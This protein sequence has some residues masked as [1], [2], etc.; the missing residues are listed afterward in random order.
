M[1]DDFLRDLDAAVEQRCACLCGQQITAMSPSAYFASEE[2]ALR[3]QHPGTEPTSRRTFLTEVV[4]AV[5]EFWRA[6]E[7]YM[8]PLLAMSRYF[9][10]QETDPE[11]VRENALQARRNR[12]V[13]PRGRSRP[14]RQ[15]D[16]AGGLSVLPAGRLPYRPRR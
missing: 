14:P 7:P 6:M 4:A 3:W 11:K 8:S 12:N 5:E 9:E 16:P 13:G 15:V 10:E 1:A 2:C